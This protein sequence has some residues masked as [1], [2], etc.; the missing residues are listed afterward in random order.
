MAKY[1]DSGEIVLLLD[2]Y[3]QEGQYLFDSLKQAGYECIAIVI[4]ENDFLPE[5]FF[6]IY[7]LFIGNYIKKKKN[8]AQIL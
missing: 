2:S 5:A 1:I 7:D 6:S 3:T 8:K 4:N